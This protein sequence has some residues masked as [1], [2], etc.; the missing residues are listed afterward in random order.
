MCLHGGTF[1]G[2]NGARM[3]RDIMRLRWIW[4]EG[5]SRYVRRCRLDRGGC[6]DDWPEGPLI[7]FQ[8]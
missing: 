1:G 2:M 6:S 8:P 4:A 3:R 5:A 7:P